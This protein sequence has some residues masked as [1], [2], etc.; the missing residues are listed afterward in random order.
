M[1]T[2]ITI[3]LDNIAVKI[4]IEKLYIYKY[5]DIYNNL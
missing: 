4:F 2:W 1:L 3:V 5:N